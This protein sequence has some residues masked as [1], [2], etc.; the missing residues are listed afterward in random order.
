MRRRAGGAP[1]SASARRARAAFARPERTSAPPGSAAARRSSA[2]IAQQRESRALGREDL[3]VVER[4]PVA[5]AAEPRGDV[6]VPWYGGDVLVRVVTAPVDGEGAAGAVGGEELDDAE[7]AVVAGDAHRFVA[8]VVGLLLVGAAAISSATISVSPFSQAM[9][10]GVVALVVGL[11]HVG[12][13]RDQR[14]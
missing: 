3:E 12:V 1:A 7:V 10:S 11:V 4:R 9:N 5:A 2:P 6:V 8:I 14:R 13:R